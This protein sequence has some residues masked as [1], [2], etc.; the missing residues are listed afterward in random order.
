MEGFGAANGFNKLVGALTKAQ[1]DLFFSPDKGIGLSLL[2][3]TVPFDGS[4]I[5]PISKESLLACAGGLFTVRDAVNLKSLGVR[6]W[7][8]AW[9]PPFEWK[10]NS[11]LITSKYADYAQYLATYVRSFENVT[12]ATLYALSSANEPNIKVLKETST[13]F[14]P[15]A[16][17]KFVRQF[18]SP[19]LVNFT[20]LRLMYPETSSYGGLKLYTSP[21]VPDEVSIIGFH[22]YDSFLPNIPTKNKF[23]PKQSFW[24][25]E[26][27]GL[28][29]Q[30]STGA[31]D[32]SMDDALFWAQNIHMWIVNGQLNAWHWWWVTGRVDGPDHKQNQFLVN[33][34][35]EVAMR[36]YTIGSFSKFVRPGFVR[37]AA[38]PMPLPL[39][40]ISA[41]INPKKVGY[42]VV[43]LNLNRFS[44]QIKFALGTDFPI[45]SIT[46]WVVAE[47][48][49][50]V[51]QPAIQVQTNGS[52]IYDLPPRSVVSFVH[53]Q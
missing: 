50:L 36:A 22:G 3:M 37:V 23:S 9:S 45:S 31:W 32:P 10:V 33:L 40:Y 34:E 51:A 6:L 7:A 11:R 15:V 30:T 27:S 35:G 2:R 12:N 49:R 17:R 18:L 53:A 44:R 19:S 48:V 29:S 16:L 38:T 28:V 46:P 47:G 1:I 42:V 14:P 43:A 5:S 25:S 21:T 20:S 13:V 24:L 4:C 52:F 39:V 8:S 26:V 41:F